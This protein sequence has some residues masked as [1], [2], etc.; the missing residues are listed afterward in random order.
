MN[1]VSI[2]VPVYNGEKY[3]EKCINSILKQTYKNV[4][5]IIIND[6]SVDKTKKILDKYS[7]SIIVI[8]KKNTGVSDSRNVGIDKAT[9]D[10]IM[11]CDADD[12]LCDDTIEIAVNKINNYDAVRFSHYVVKNN[13]INKKENSDDVYSDIDLV[14]NDNKELVKNLLENKTEG[15]LWNYLLRT[16]V[17]KDNKIYFDDDLF[18]QEDVVFLLEYFFKIKKLKVISTPLYNYYK[19]FDSVTQNESSTIKNLSSIW[20]VREKIINLLEINNNLDYKKL[21]E[22]RF[23]NLQ[24]MYFLDFYI[25]FNRKKFISYI[26]EI[27]L[28]NEKYYDEILSSNILSKKWFLFIKLLRLKKIHLF[29]VYIRCYMLVKK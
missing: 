9:G 7:D 18:Y 8:N 12:W 23:L 17:I 26:K 2:V 1:K 14:V 3:I 5:L 25:R 21:V 16:E 15:H 11:F 4:E 29:R 20:L 22:Q 19:N 28:A 10:Y 6:G 24:L 13:Q 27:S